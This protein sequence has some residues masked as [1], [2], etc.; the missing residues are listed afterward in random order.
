VR[1]GTGT[2]PK[3][4]GRFEELAVDE[5][6]WKSLLAT[7]QVDGDLHPVGAAGLDAYERQTGFALPGSYRSFCRVFGPGDVGGWYSV[8]VPAYGG[9]ARNRHRY[10]LTA[11]TAAYR[12]G[13]EWVEYAADPRQF[14]QAVIFADDCT[15]AVF[16]CDPAEVTVRDAH[17]RAVYV[18]W[19]DWT[20]ERVS[21]TFG[22]FVKI[23]LHRG[24]RTLYDEAPRLGFRAAWFGRGTR[25]KDKG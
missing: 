19:R 8:A 12:D 11:K 3:D 6:A 18:V 9:P 10:D 16:F 1:G 4:V 17:E 20:Q 13:R 25:K 24:D 22:E 7:L 15:G 5:S 2:T 14:E 21:D 23:C